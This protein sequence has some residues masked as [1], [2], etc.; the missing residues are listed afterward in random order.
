MLI[1][2]VAAATQRR[3]APAER[4]SRSDRGCHPTLESAIVNDK[5]SYRIHSDGGAYGW[6][7]VAGG[8][9]I[10]ASGTASDT[11]QARVRAIRA[12]LREL[13]GRP[14]AQWRRTG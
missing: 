9:E 8:H 5:L 11:V 10:L 12:A 6:T 3:A 13:P 14:S 4:L 1:C 7:V 2:P